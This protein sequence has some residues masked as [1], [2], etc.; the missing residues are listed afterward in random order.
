MHN[1]INKTPLNKNIKINSLENIMD[2]G[3]NLSGT[4][5]S[6]PLRKGILFGIKPSTKAIA[7]YGLYQSSGLGFGKALPKK[8]N[9]MYNLNSYLTSA[10]LGLMLGDGWLECSA[11]SRSINARFGLKQ[12]IINLPFAW[13]TYLLFSVLCGSLP[14]M[15]TGKRGNTTTLS[16]SFKTRALPCLTLFYLQFYINGTKIV[17]ASL[18][19]NLDGVALAY[20]IMSDGS[21]EKGGLILCT[22]NFTMKEVCLLIS[23]LHYN[24]GIDCTLRLV[25]NKYYRIYI[26]KNSMDT[27]RKLVMPHMH[28]H[29]LYK[30]KSD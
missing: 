22:D 18:L 29:F 3:P 19:I 25:K 13:S 21:F 1:N 2:S 12:S 30:I 6:A 4:A 17:P 27:V 7:P 15:T 10:L 8:V 23:I 5:P 11:K 28:P 9:G 26:R 16:I 14:I 24:F 20:W